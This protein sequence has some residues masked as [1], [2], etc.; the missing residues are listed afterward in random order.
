MSPTYYVLAETRD[1]MSGYH[2]EWTLQIDVGESAAPTTFSGF[3]A[4]KNNGG[5]RGITRSGDYG[6]G[7]FIGGT[8]SNTTTYLTFNA[9]DKLYFVSVNAPNG[10]TNIRLHLEGIAT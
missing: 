4:I 5:D 8:Y 7:S 2:I 9:G 10:L 1:D 3:G 6:G